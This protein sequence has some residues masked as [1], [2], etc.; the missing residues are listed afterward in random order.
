VGKGIGT[1]MQNT[2]GRAADHV[3][4][5][6]EQRILE[7]IWADGQALPSERDLMLEFGISR[8]VVR[9]A[10]RLLSARGLVEAKPRFRPV[11]RKAG[12]EAVVEAA[13]S[14]VT[15]LL[16]QP[17]GVRNMFDTR[18]LIEAGLVREAAKSAN[19]ADIVALKNALAANAAAIND[20]DLFYRTDTAFH[21]VFYAIPRNP[22]LPAIH[23]AYSTW[24]AP[25]WSQ[26]P[27]LLD[28]NKANLAAHTAIFDA[29]LMRDPDAAEAALRSHLIAAWNQVRQ[30]FGDI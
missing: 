19:A 12:F 25:Q 15:N 1:M 24:L 21:A 9:E 10:V 6:L 22:V 27:R 11:V 16:Q 8:T 20:S 29:V 17:G 13:G 23:S 5:T 2:T 3:V 4:S 30:T 14:V 28:R 7:G 18:I 26:M